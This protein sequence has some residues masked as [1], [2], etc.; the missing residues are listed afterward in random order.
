MTFHMENVLSHLRHLS[1]EELRDEAKRAGLNCGPI[2]KS[3]RSFLEKKLAR[4][5]DE[6]HQRGGLVEPDKVPETNEPGRLEG[7]QADIVSIRQNDRGEI[8]NGGRQGSKDVGEEENVKKGRECGDLDKKSFMEV[9]AVTNGNDSSISPPSGVFYGVCPAPGSSECGIVYTDRTLALCAVRALP[10]SRFKAFS[11]WEKAHD[12]ASS[13]VSIANSPNRG[14]MIGKKCR[15]SFV[16]QANSFC[17]PRVQDLTTKL[18]QAAE[19]GD[20][21]ELYC[22]AWGNPCYLI[23]PGDV[24]TIV[25]VGCRYNA[26]HVAAKAGQADFIHHLLLL[27]SLPSFLTLAFPSDSSISREQRAAR[28]TDLYLNTPEKGKFDTPLHLAAEFG[29]LAV[30]RLL[31][32]HPSLVCEPRNRCGST[33]LQVHTSF[34]TDDSYLPSFH[35]R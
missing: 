27:I 10:G 3:T 24:P 15:S 18:R 34:S 9:V 6:M 7:S 31:L 22:L 32:S 8:E 13:S 5:I 17:T 14:S 16:K 2:T 23:G 25:Q 19:R 12:F 28:L 35:G 1:S 11:S 26:L 29:H 33:P 4:L 21:D 20:I 30:V